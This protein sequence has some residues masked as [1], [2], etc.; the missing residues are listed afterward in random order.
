MW[1]TVCQLN[2]LVLK[3]PTY[4]FEKS[5]HLTENVRT[6]FL[7]VKVWVPAVQTFD[8]LEHYELQK[9]KKNNKAIEQK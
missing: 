6:A 4:F 2:S 5:F 3:I 1:P 9:T 8:T 7:Y